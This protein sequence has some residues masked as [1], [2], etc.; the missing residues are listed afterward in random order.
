MAIYSSV[1]WAYLVS[2]APKKKKEPRKKW[3]T[4]ARVFIFLISRE[5]CYRT[6]RDEVGKKRG[7]SMERSKAGTKKEVH[8]TN[9]YLTKIQY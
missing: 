3:R 6:R 9:H 4:H 8:K 1:S 7:V 2:L 5:K